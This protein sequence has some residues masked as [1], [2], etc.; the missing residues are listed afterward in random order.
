MV[1]GKEQKIPAPGGIQTHNLCVMRHVLYRCDTTATHKGRDIGNPSSI[2]CKLQFSTNLLFRQL[3]LFT[4]E[5]C[6]ARLD[7]AGADRDQEQPDEGQRSEIRSR[8]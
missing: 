7:A 1:L 8:V 5:G 4:A 2:S 6:D 3:E